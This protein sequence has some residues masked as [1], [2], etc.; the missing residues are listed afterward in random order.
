[1][2]FHPLLTKFRAIFSFIVLNSMQR[3]KSTC[4]IFVKHY[5]QIFGGNVQV[6]C[7]HCFKLIWWLSLWLF[8]C[9][10]VKCVLCDFMYMFQSKINFGNLL[11]CFHLEC[12]HNKIYY[13]KYIFFSNEI[14]ILVHYCNLHKFNA[15]FLL[16]VSYLF[17]LIICFFLLIVILSTSFYPQIIIRDKNCLLF[18]QNLYIFFH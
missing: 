17:S 5:P 2:L 18:H 4:F 9:W 8:L 3:T 13:W 11:E 10:F 14:T 1:M 15:L 6:I 16:Q 7:V 12:F